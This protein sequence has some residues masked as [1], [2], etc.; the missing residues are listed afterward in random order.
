VGRQGGIEVFGTIEI[1][2]RCGNMA[3]LKVGHAALDIH[4]GLVR[5]CIEVVRQALQCAF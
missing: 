5:V 2:N 1:C 3:K 4:S